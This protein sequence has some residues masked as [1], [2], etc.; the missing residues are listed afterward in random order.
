LTAI[1]E[2]EVLTSIISSY[3]GLDLGNLTGD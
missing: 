1:E 2:D 3:M